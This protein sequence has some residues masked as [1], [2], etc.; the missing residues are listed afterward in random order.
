MNYLYE[1]IYYEEKIELF[2]EQKDIIFDKFEDKDVELIKDLFILINFEEFN[3]IVVQLKQFGIMFVEK[4]MIK[5]LFM[6]IEE[7]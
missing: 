2:E 3:M 5:M 1:D 6:E 4:L 7:G